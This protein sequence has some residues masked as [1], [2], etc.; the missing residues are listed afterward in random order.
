MFPENRSDSSNDIRLDLDRLNGYKDSNFD[1]NKWIYD[2]VPYLNKHQEQ[3]LVSILNDIHNKE[4][5][6]LTEEETKKTEIILNSIYRWMQSETS[7]EYV[8][9][10]FNPYL[11]KYMYQKIAELY[12]SLNIE[13]KSKEKFVKNIVLTKFTTEKQKNMQMVSQRSPIQKKC[14]AQRIF[15]L[16]VKSK[17]PIIGHNVLIDLAFIYS[18][19]QE[20]LPK[21]LYEFKEKLNLLFPTIYDILTILSDKNIKQLFSAGQPLGLEATY[22]LLANQSKV[23]ETKIMLEEKSNYLNTNHLHD[24]GYN[25]YLIGILFNNQR[26]LLW[27]IQRLS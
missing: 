2:G 22:S 14:E 19:F 1:F 9:T 8:I 25:S 17:I 20:E 4:I 23:S 21:S 13:C 15:N 18:N 12:P 6:T 16:L 5:L 11:R 24:E 27:K 7:S 26:L 3:S 10:N